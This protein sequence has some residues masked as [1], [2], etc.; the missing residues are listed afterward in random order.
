MSADELKKI[1]AALPSEAPAKPAK[2]RKILVFDKTEG[3]HHD[4]IPCCDKAIELMG[5]K[6]GAYTARRARN[7]RLHAGEPGPVRRRVA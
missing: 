4:S 7:G 5:E 3:F 6:T 1:E 2:P